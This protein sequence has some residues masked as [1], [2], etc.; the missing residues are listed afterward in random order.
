ML[1]MPRARD[2]WLVLSAAEGLFFMGLANGRVCKV[3]FA[4]MA[5]LC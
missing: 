4:V 2:S 1:H 3:V 5:K